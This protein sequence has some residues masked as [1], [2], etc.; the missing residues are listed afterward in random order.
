MSRI[1]HRHWTSLLAPFLLLGCDPADPAVSPRLGQEPLT[2]PEFRVLDTSMPSTEYCDN[3]RDWSPERL[4]FENAVLEETNR[5]R[6]QGADCGE[7]GQFEAAP[8]VRLNSALR[9]AARAHSV[10]MAERNYFSHDDPEGLGSVERVANTQYRWFALGENIAAGYPTPEAVV[11][12]WKES[13]GHCANMMNPNFTQL[14]V[15]YFPGGTYSH[16]WTQVFAQ[17][18]DLPPNDED[19]QNSSAAPALGTIPLLALGSM[20]FYVYLRRR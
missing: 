3:V 20:L 8:P 9:C 13:D 15:G 7:R 18:D 17:G 19:D 11:L 12:G 2:S 10:D 1:H 14:G 4:A 16:Y 6:A 5:V